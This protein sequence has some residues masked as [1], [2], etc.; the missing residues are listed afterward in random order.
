[1]VGNHSLKSALTSNLGFL[2]AEVFEEVSVPE[3]SLEERYRSRKQYKLLQPSAV[4]TLLNV[5]HA[6][7]AG[8]RIKK[9]KKCFPTGEG[10]DF[11]RQMDPGNI[12]EWMVNLFSQIMTVLF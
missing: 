6:C 3:K 2:V 9:K 8:C 4:Q 1:M 5:Q 12:D 11:G 10:M 7:S